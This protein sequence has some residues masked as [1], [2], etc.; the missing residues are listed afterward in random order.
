M[1]TYKELQLS[2]T[3]TLEKLEE[4]NDELLEYKK[5]Y[6]EL[7]TGRGNSPKKNHKSKS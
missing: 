6:G 2:F 4:I 3:V 1:K 7:R 5:I